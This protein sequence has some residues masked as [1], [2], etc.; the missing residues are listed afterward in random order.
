V[1]IQKVVREGK[2]IRT[3][4]LD[5]RVLASPLGHPRIGIVVPRYAAPVVRRNRLKRRLRELSRTQLLP[6]APAIDMV[7]RARPKAYEATFSALGADILRVITH[8]GHSR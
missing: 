4:H 3:R 8:A 2:R 7:I 5:V 1:D 6:V